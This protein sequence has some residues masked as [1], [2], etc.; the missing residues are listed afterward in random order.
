MSD[1][2]FAGIG[3]V[4]LVG[5][6]FVLFL[7]MFW[8]SNNSSED[9]PVEKLVEEANQG[10]GIGFLTILIVAAIACLLFMY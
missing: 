6:V 8:P 4:A 9:A 3:I 1:A 5:V 10:I 7:M 2:E